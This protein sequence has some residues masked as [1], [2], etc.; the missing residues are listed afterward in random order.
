VRN[1]KW[2]QALA[3]VGAVLAIVALFVDHD[4][5]IED[6]LFLFGVVAMSYGLSTWS[7]RRRRIKTVP[8]PPVRPA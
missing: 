5:I 7:S 1:I 4:F 3:V 2:Y 6:P 8:P